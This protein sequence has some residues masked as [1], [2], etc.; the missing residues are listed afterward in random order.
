VTDITY[1][2]W[3][4]FSALLGLLL[5]LD[6]LVFHRRDHVPKLRESACWTLFWFT[7][8]V[9][10]N[11]LLWWRQGREAGVSFLT[12]YV[13]EWSL[14]MDNVFV[15]AVIFRFFRVPMQ[16]Q[17]RVLFWGILGAIGL[18]LAFI[19]AGTRLIESFAWILP[20]FGLLLIYTSIKLTLGSGED[21]HPEK[22]LVLRLA[23][24]WLPVTK[25]HHEQ[26][27][28][29]FFVRENGRLCITPLFL[30]LLVI[31]S[32]DIL[33]AVDSV[34]AIFGITLDPFIVFTSN[35]FAIMGLRSLYFLLAGMIGMFRYLH[36]GLAVVLAFVGG[37]MIAEYWIPHEENT[38]LIPTWIKLVVIAVMLGVSVEASLVSNRLQARREKRGEGKK[39]GES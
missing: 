33:F 24:W 4:G 1:W 9:A 20:L 39:E 10:F 18:R 26:H 14:S 8:A 5:G 36:Y 35:I 17:H 16:Y 15:F 13:I 19:L 7:L 34:P 27:G 21:A 11:G 22:S 25:E 12:G 6:L 30:V 32:T 31:E 3:I 28:R 37:N 38:H 2:H 23:R 29:A